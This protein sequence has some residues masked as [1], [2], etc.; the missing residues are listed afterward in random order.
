MTENGWKMN[1]W[2]LC[3]V[4][5]GMSPTSLYYLVPFSVNEYSTA[6]LWYAETCF[7]NNMNCQFD[8]LLRWYIFSLISLNVI[9]FWMNEMSVYI[10]R[11]KNVAKWLTT[12]CEAYFIPMNDTRS[13]WISDNCLPAARR[14]FDEFKLQKWINALF[15]DRFH[16]ARIKNETNETETPSLF[17]R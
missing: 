13:M 14:G 17:N 9:C 16:T 5:N 7:H 3:T 15:V 11:V 6:I 2:R 10:E 12:S 1:W 8:I 4:S